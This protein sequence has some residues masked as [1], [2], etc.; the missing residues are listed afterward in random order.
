MCINKDANANG[1]GDCGGEA[2][3]EGDNDNKK[4]LGVE[5]IFGSH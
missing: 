5:S 2:G 1:R 4:S 3:Q